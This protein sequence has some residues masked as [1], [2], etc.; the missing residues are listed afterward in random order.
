MRII[1]LFLIACFMATNCVA[2]YSFIGSWMGSLDVG[3]KLRIVF[4][5]MDS[6]NALFGTMDSPDQFKFGKPCDAVTAT[7]D[8][9]AITAVNGKLEYRGKLVGPGTIL[10][11][12][13]QN[14]MQFPLNLI[15]T[16]KPAVMSRPQTPKPPFD[17]NAEDVVYYNADSSIQYG[18]TITIPKGKGSFPAILM[19]TGSGQQNRDEEIMGHKPF[20]VIA[21]YLTKKGYIVLR[22]DDRGMG[23]STGDFKS[24]TSLDFMNDARVSL[25]YLRSRSEVDKHKVGLMGHSEGGMIAPMIAANDRKI[26]FIVLLAGPG[27]K[28]EQLMEEQNAASLEKSGLSKEAIDSYLKLFKQLNKSL[29]TS[30]NE[31]QL[32]AAVRK[33]VDDWKSKTP[34]DFVSATT[35]I[36]DERSEKEF[37]N[38]VSRQISTNWYKYFIAYD[39]GINLRK[40]SCKA[41]ALNGEK[42]IQVIAKS[43]LAGIKSSLEKSKSPAYSVMEL[44]GLNHLFQHCQSCTIEEYAQIEETFS[45]DALQT[46]ADWLNKNV[47]E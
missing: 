4:N 18:A 32:K 35:H 37:V 36:T 5:I 9:I 47:K 2:Q 41:L 26:D 13:K 23:K 3:Q 19:I 7:G 14:G 45:T 17:Y 42:D 27:V 46:I 12:F 33:D 28:I 16:D 21:D 31:D 15:K 44:Q 11:V 43:N 34:A 38:A 1:N 25:G 29:L 6:A 30:A 20:A 8:S 24:S 10:G 39:P 40:L 22:V